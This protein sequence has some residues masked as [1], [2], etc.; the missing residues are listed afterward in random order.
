MNLFII[1]PN[2]LV[3]AQVALTCTPGGVPWG[4]EGW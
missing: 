3:M 4:E 2:G 1:V